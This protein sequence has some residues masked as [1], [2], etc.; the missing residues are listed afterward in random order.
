MYH[1]DKYKSSS[2]GIVNFLTFMLM[3]F[4]TLNA[5]AQKYYGYKDQ[6]SYYVPLISSYNGQYNITISGDYN[7]RSEE[8]RVGHECLHMRRSWKLP[9][10]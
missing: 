5:N 1:S 4:F 6:D 2:I 7:D 9:T 10:H 3:L 8:R